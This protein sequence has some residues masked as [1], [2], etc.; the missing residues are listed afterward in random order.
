MLRFDAKRFSFRLAGLSMFLAIPFSG[1]YISWINSERVVVAPSQSQFIHLRTSDDSN[2][3]AAR[4]E[5]DIPVLMK[6]AKVPGLS[7]ALIR[8]SKIAWSHGFGVRS[9]QAGG[10]VT[11]STIFEAA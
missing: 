3:V 4:L 9:T 6:Q 7:I 10:P 2:A 8:N 11:A 5:A 1:W